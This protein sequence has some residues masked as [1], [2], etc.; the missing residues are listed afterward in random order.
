MCAND[1]SKEICKLDPKKA[2]G[3]DDIHPKLVK[4]AATCISN[5][6]AYV[7]N[8]SISNG[9]FPD[10]LKIAKVI[11]VYKKGSTSEVGNYR[12]ISILPV[13]SKIFES[14]INK[15]LCAYLDKF[16]VLSKT[17]FGFR[18]K[19]ST[20]LALADLTAD[21]A[22]HMDNGS[23]TLGI[24]IDLRK[25][26]DTINHNILLKKLEHYGI[27]GIA[28]NWFETYLHLRKQY[29]WAGGS[30]SE[31][32]DILCGVPQGSILGPLLFLIYINDICNSSN[33]LKFRLFADDT[34]LFYSTN[35]S[36]INL[37][38]VDKELAKVNNWCNANK[39]TIN[40]D[41]TNY[42]IFKTNQRSTNICGNLTINSTPIQCVSNSVYLGVVL[43]SSLTWREH[44]NKI[45]RKIS[46]KI[47]VI[48]RLRHLLPRHVLLMLYNS[49]ILPHLS[50]CIEIWGNT[51]KSII[52]PLYK[53]Q[54]KLVRL[55]T[56]SAPRAPSAPLFKKLGI[57]NVYQLC[58][59]QTCVFTYDL[60]HK[61]YAHTLE[62]YVNK[63]PHNYNTRLKFNQHLYMPS[64]NLRISRN[65]L[66]YC[67]VNHWN[68]LPLYI[69]NLSSR[70]IFKHT[71]K[72]HLLNT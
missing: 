52:D 40:I 47:G 31:Q 57:L 33:I 29:V 54:K 65:S 67:I 21:I 44:I 36:R 58:K 53:L 64:F 4:I 18:S 20:K 10:Q 56:F 27:R 12:P 45:V 30:V 63:L 23:T 19:H 25:A 68:E 3:F 9:V 7:V 5:P 41:K 14:I 34:N 51:F 35:N 46:S 66:P 24:F 28:L 43:D 15:Q 2:T 48:G 26:F 71:L 61:H 13:F 37:D 49:I 11:P 39:L 16:D 69:K 60:I 22:E 42:M 8:Y 50:Y 6:L 38:V 72:L 1:I 62:H 59:L 70:T 32:R 55:I 17:Q